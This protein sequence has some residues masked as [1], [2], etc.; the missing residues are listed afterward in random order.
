MSVLEC[1]KE[2]S[3]G[4]ITTFSQLRIATKVHFSLYAI[5]ED[6][7]KIYAADHLCHCVLALLNENDFAMNR[8]PQIISMGI[9]IDFFCK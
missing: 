1:Q 7:I 2:V 8:I 4:L 9:Q 5:C 6:Y 3:R